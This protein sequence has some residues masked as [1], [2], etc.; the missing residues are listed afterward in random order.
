METTEQQLFT[1]IH[2]GD[3]D[4]FG[5]LYDL[6][7]Q[8]IYRFVYY[9][10]FNKE[11]AWD[12]TSDVFMKAYEKFHQ[13]NSEKGNFSSWIYAI[14]KNIIIDH[15]RSHKETQSYSDAFDVS[16]EYMTK[17]KIEMSVDI[18]AVREHIATLDSVTR[19]VLML[20]LWEDMSYKEIAEIIGKT[21]ANCKVIFSRS[22]KKL[23]AQIPLTS[24]L[25]FITFHL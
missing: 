21:E 3:K 11:L 25:L 9:K 13:F 22:I 15:Y 6:Y 16:D 20:R 19:E 4:A 2:D 7:V 1:R 23:R 18:A 8:K 14:A 12:L 5:A 24:F 17:Q 10:T